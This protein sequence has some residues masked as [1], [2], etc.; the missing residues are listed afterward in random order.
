MKNINEIILILMNENKKLSYKQ[1]RIKASRQFKIN[2][3]EYI[4]QKKNN[5]KPS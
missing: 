2:R 1:A 5:G 4:L 3:E